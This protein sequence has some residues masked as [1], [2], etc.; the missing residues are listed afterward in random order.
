MCLQALRK[1]DAVLDENTKLKEDQ[2][3]LLARLKAK[4]ERVKEL[5]KEL[6]QKNVKIQEDREAKSKKMILTHQSKYIETLDKAIQTHS[7][8][9]NVSNHIRM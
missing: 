6:E 8:D 2:S 7:M 3:D 4:K 9:P 1:Y 5:V